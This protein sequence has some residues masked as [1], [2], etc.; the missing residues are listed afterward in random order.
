MGELAMCLYRFEAFSTGVNETK[1]FL[2]GGPVD[3]VVCSLSLRYCHFTNRQQMTN[4]KNYQCKLS[5]TVLHILIAKDVLNS[6]TEVTSTKIGPV[7]ILAHWHL[8]SFA[9][10]VRRLLS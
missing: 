6:T 4:F 3:R 8:L 10:C 1:G 2:V 7:C 9:V 5:L